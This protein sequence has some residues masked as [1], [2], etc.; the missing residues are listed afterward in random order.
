MK[1]IFKYAFAL[2]L[3]VTGIALTSCTDEY[4]YPGP[5]ENQDAKPYFLQQKMK[6]ELEKGKGYFDV[7]VHR[8][9]AS[10]AAEIPVIFEPSKKG[11]YFTA[12]PNAVF[13]AGKKEGYIRISY[14][15]ADVKRGYIKGILRFDLEKNVGSTYGL[16]TA[17]QF[18]AGSKTGFAK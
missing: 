7:P 12:A 2:L 10:A 1:N 9:D 11:N 15:D 17:M 6:F 18:S 5:G 16:F 3:G 8:L 14:K 4:E 13:E